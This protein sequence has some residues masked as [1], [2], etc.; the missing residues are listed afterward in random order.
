MGASLLA[1]AKSIYYIALYIAIEVDNNDMLIGPKQKVKEKFSRQ[2]FIKIIWSILRQ[3][4]E[5]LAIRPTLFN[6]S[7]I[8]SDRLKISE[9]G[10]L[11]YPLHKKESYTCSF[12]LL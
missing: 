5:N 11:L 7:Q 9:L 10:C 12:L 2:L 1:V 6:Q 8:S 4:T 3:R